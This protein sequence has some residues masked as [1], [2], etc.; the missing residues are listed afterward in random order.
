MVCRYVLP[1]ALVIAVGLPVFPQSSNQETIPFRLSHAFGLILISAEVNGA[2]ALLVLDTGSNHTAI[3][4]RFVDVAS[5]H[6]RNKVSSERGS[7]YAGTGIFTKASL[8]VGP[9]VWRDHQIL[10][11]DMKEISG[12][13]GENVDGILGMDFLSEFETV[14]VDVRHHKL[15]LR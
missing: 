5:P 1:V 4:P 11:M 3:S 10:A 13:L 9:V 2:P 7:S 8:K 12:T 14:V 6:L 15:I